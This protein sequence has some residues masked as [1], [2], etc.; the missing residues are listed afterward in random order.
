MPATERRSFS[1]LKIDLPKSLRSTEKHDETE[2]SPG[3]SASAEADRRVWDKS[4]F[5]QQGE[6]EGTDRTSDRGC[7]R[8]RRT[9]RRFFHDDRGTPSVAVPCEDPRRRC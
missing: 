1:G 3:G 5:A 6:A 9:N 7:L 2:Q 4:P 8:R